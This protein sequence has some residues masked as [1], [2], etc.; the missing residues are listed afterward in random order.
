MFKNNQTFDLDHLDDLV[1]ALNDLDNDLT[2]RIEVLE[3][4]LEDRSNEIYMSHLERVNDFT[5]QLKQTAYINAGMTT[6]NS[7]QIQI[8]NNSPHAY[9]VEH[10]TGRYRGNREWWVVPKRKIP[11]ADRAIK[12]YGFEPYGYGREDGEPLYKVHGQKPQNFFANTYY[13]I[14]SE[15]NP[16]VRGIF[17]W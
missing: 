13:E 7:F 17:K 15:I 16:T 6:D 5:G 11:D 1:K 9:Y 3:T 14:F 8:G 10:G 4:V 2:D 12:A